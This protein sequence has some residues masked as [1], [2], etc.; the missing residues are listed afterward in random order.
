MSWIKSNKNNHM[1]CRFGY[2]EYIINNLG[3][4]PF[5][6]R[7]RYNNNIKC[8]FSS[9]CHNAHKPSDI[10][11][12]YYNNAF[13]QLNKKNIN[14]PKLYTEIYNIIKK[15]LYR[16]KNKH[17]I[18]RINNLDSLNFIE[19][20]QLWRD[21][22]CHYRR[23]VK[24]YPKNINIQVSEKISQQ[25]EGYKYY[26]TIP[27]FQ[28]TDESIIWPF[29]RKTRYCL[30]FKKY[31]NNINQNKKILLNDLCC[32]SYNCKEGVHY[33]DELICKDDFLF[34]KCDCIPK[35]IFKKNKKE[36][37]NKIILLE[38]SLKQLNEKK[39]I[40]IKDK[41][42]INKIQNKI[43][44][45]KYIYNNTRRMI[46]YTEKGMLSFEQQMK[47]YNKKS[48]DKISSIEN[49]LSLMNSTNN[50][51]KIINLKNI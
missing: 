51:I 5:I 14:F 8:N 32:G 36:L 34:G 25:N 22:S 46:H 48:Y 35:N 6:T 50:N 16:V 2:A 37:Y 24:L 9:K 44:S 17:F 20:V 1:M 18:K 47:H 15:E 10:K 7:S 43:K 38:S 42:K 49:M 45:K 4:S 40:N 23:M 28:L 41:R 19:I 11:L 31:I 27:L 29:E 12:L 26:K 13:Q 33:T 21:L 39:N 3:Y 30:Q